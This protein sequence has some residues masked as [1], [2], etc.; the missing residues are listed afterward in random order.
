MDER[1]YC[2]EAMGNVMRVISNY[3]VKFDI[4]FTIRTHK[5]S[6]NTEVIGFIVTGIKDKNECSLMIYGDNIDHFQYYLD[7][8]VRQ[9][10]PD[11][12]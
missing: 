10:K 2:Y 3:A 5:S 9:L 8:I 7:E 12:M 1:T 6:L 11:I 4:E